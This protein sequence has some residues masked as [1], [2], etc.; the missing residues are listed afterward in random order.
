ML[1]PDSPTRRTSVVGQVTLDLQ[2]AVLLTSGSEASALT[3]LVNRVADPVDA[4]VAADRLVAGVD[5]DDLE[6]LVGGILVNPVRVEDTEVSAATANTLLGQGLQIAAPLDADNTMG[7]GLTTSATTVDGVLATTTANTNAV[8][9]ESL[10][11]HVSKTA[12]L[13]GAARAASAVNR[14]KLTVFPS[15][16]AQN[17]AESVRLLLLVQFLKILVGTH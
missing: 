5:K 13:V 14:G 16:N 10:L 15:A 17:E 6:E 12:G 1:L 3:V 7:S 8:D 2:A 4:G 9:D 11:G